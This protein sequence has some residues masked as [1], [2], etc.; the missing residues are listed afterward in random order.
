[1]QPS[2]GDGYTMYY[3]STDAY[4]Q[5]LEYEELHEARESAKEARK[6]AIASI[7]ISA[8]LAIGAICVSLKPAQIKLTE[9]QIQEIKGLFIN[10]NKAKK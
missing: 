4:F 2:N 1:M 8:F 9:S 10:L 5:L 7:I 3:L 6:I